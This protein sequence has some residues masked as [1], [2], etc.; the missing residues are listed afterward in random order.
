MSF[1]Y[2]LENGNSFEG[3]SREHLGN[4]ARIREAK[5]AGRGGIFCKI[6]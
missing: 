4:A 1:I 2:F 3:R 6:M 5:F